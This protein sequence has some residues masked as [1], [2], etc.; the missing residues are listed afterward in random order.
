M[1]VSPIDRNVNNSNKFERVTQFINYCQVPRLEALEEY[2]QLSIVRR[3]R[4][5]A[6]FGTGCPL[7]YSV[8]LRRTF[9]RASERLCACR[10]IHNNCVCVCLTI[11][12]TSASAYSR[13][14]IE[15]IGRRKSSYKRTSAARVDDGLH[16]C[17]GNI[18]PGTPVFTCTLYV[19]R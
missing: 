8:Q 15:T 16:Q 1:D 5:A 14:A 12:R 7:I 13:H 19:K 4:P 11:F 18:W 17:A 2:D 3:P 10:H 9:E 6:A